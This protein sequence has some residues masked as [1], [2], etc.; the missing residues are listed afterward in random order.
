VLEFMQSEADVPKGLERMGSMNVG[1]RGSTT[2][3]QPG[4]GGSVAGSGN[5]D[6]GTRTSSGVLRL[7][8]AGGI[9]PGGGTPRQM[10]Y[11]VG[12]QS[13]VPRSPLRFYHCTPHGG[14]GSTRSGEGGYPDTPD[15]GVRLSPLIDCDDEKA[16]RRVIEG[17]GSSKGA[18]GPSGGSGEPSS[19]VKMQIDFEKQPR[20]EPPIL[21]ETETC[22][23]GLT[24]PLVTSQGENSAALERT[25]QR[26]V[27]QGQ[28]VSIP[29]GV[30]WQ[31]IP[32]QDFTNAPLPPP[33]ETSR[34][35][36][37]IHSLASL[38]A[39]LASIGDPPPLPG[40]DD[41]RSSVSTQHSA[42]AVMQTVPNPELRA[43]RRVRVGIPFLAQRGKDRRLQNLLAPRLA[44]MP[45]K[46]VSI[47]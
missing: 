22:F 28:T 31:P 42:D 23:D 20:S 8:G 43:A 4:Q 36:F 24:G 37:G 11:V 2:P 29:E 10:T 19:S 40:W 27:Q 16:L 44:P 47:Q 26:R 14:S 39:Q 15:K 25:F 12:S 21:R 30:G 7:Q 38:G 41:L 17:V 13:Q 3:K 1:L 45:L 6:D 46:L 33:M 9:S 5:P 34:G 35:P 32:R 18:P